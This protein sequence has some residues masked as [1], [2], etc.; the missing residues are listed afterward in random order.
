M[1][2][3]SSAETPVSW[4][5]S[6]ATEINLGAKTNYEIKIQRNANMILKHTSEIEE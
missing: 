2:F 5:S 4:A 6:L 3:C 1:F